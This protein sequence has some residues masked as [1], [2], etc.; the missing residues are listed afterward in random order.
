MSLESGIKDRDITEK[1]HRIKWVGNDKLRIL[2]ED[3]LEKLVALDF[4]ADG[5]D[6][7]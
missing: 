2:N 3:G 4:E 7:T 1:I 5:S 6:F